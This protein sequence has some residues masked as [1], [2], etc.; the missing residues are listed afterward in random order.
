MSSNLFS[1]PQKYEFLQKTWI[2]LLGKKI[3]LRSKICSPKVKN[4]LLKLN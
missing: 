4:L 2:L 3:G 1:M